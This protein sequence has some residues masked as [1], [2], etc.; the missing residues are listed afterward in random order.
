[1]NLTLT[2]TFLI[3]RIMYQTNVMQ[4]QNTTLIC[5]AMVQFIIF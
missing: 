4:C 2:F 5:A 1:M 3:F